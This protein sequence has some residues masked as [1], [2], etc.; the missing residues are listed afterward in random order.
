MD[1]CYECDPV[2]VAQREELANKGSFGCYEPVYLCEEHAEEFR[3][4]GVTLDRDEDG[5][6]TNIEIN[7]DD[8]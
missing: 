6:I 4:L 5:L 1:N 3:E 2:K 8:R 7:I